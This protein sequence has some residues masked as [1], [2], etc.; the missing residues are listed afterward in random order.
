[1]VVPSPTDSTGRSVRS[2][3]WSLKR[4]LAVVTVIVLVTAIIFVAS[5]PDSVASTHRN[6]EQTPP[7][8]TVAQDF[9]EAVQVED[10]LIKAMKMDF[11]TI[12]PAPRTS[13]L[14]LGGQLMLDPDRLV[15][16]P[17]R[18]SGEVISVGESPGLKEDGSQPL[19]IGN[20]VKQG[21]VLA[22]LW[23]RDVG[24]KKSDLVDA[25]CSLW[26]HESLFDKLKN[27]GEGTVAQRQLDEMQRLVETDLIN[28]TR[29]RRTLR[30][31]RIPEAEIVEIDHD[32]E[33]IHA[34]ANRDRSPLIPVSGDHE[35]LARDNRWAE[36]ELLAPRD[37]LI[38]EKNFTVGDVVDA[39]ADLFKIADLSRMLLLANVYEDDLP[40]LLALPAGQRHW[41]VTLPGQPSPLVAV[42]EITSIG[43]VIDPNQ[44]TAIVTGWVDNP[45]GKLR[46][47]Q[48]ARATIEMPQPEGWLAAPLSAL[49]DLGDRS[50]LLVVRR[51]NPW[52]IQRRW[53]TV[54]RRTPTEAWLQPE[55][56]TTETEPP[57]L[58]ERVVTSGAIELHTRLAEILSANALQSSLGDTSP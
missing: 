17:A 11:A 1:M 43:H 25:L 14:R 3:V 7:S 58:G 35:Q 12:R 21:Q 56:S 48:L 5:R 29:I 15:H 23:S 33:R 50:C 22:T 27:A 16:V 20:H 39:S 8:I 26:L 4:P 19:R 40:R 44:H 31:W 34:G 30:S 41:T 51:D 45:T 13:A 24:E 49:I 32:A 38:L 57:L 47:G 55:S 10:S 46:V 36:I 53:V 9:A 18:F 2:G 42:G 37:G 28:V 52:M 54:A 6:E